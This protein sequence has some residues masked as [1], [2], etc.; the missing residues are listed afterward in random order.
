MTSNSHTNGHIS[1]S[2]S[3]KAQISATEE[4]DHTELA[5]QYRTP[6][7]EPVTSF[8]ALK[9]RI[10]HH[11]ELASEY[12][13]SLW[14]EH[15]HHGYWNPPTSTIPKETAQTALID[16]LLSRSGLPSPSHQKEALRILDVGCGLGGTA[17]YLALNHGAEVLGITIS[18]HQVE[19]ARRL[20]R[21]AAAKAKPTP[22]GR[23]IDEIQQTEKPDGAIVLG[24][25]SVKFLELDAETMG[26]YFS[27]SHSKESTGEGKRFDALWISEALSHFPDKPLFFQNA[28]SV[29][30]QGGRLVIADW[31]KAE[32][33]GREAVEADIKP[34]EERRE[35][36][37]QDQWLI[38]R[39]TD[40]MLL[41]PLRTQPEYIT[42]AQQA[43][44]EIFSDPLDISQNVAKTWYVP[45]P[46]PPYK[47][48]KEISLPLSIPPSH[49]PFPFP[50]PQSYQNPTLGIYPGP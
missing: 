42:M 5:K 6:S 33:L 46:L 36:H 24:R 30:A 35:P 23:K 15:I 21:D 25:G 19:M 45:S 14:G 48:P 20:S 12:Y 8:T 40:G 39:Q 7:P 18:G 44:F 2:D 27:S 17:R 11:Y 4:D 43:G 34:I 26:E 37:V 50:F 31:F 32:G 28:F 47:T 29:L 38:D 16:L 13:Y 3:P 10:R 9:E 49:H 22:E 41:P 1:A